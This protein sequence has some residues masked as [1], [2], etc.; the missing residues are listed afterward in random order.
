MT[1]Q[2]ERYKKGFEGAPS[3]SAV[4]GPRA[5]SLDL[6]SFNF[7]V[8]T[9][10]RVRAY[11]G[12]P[13]HVLRLRAME[14]HR[15]SYFGAME[16]RYDALWLAAAAG[17]IDEAGREVRQTL[18]GEDGRD[19]LGELQHARH[20]FRERRDPQ[21]DRCEAFK[22]A[23]LRHIGHDF[24]GLAELSAQMDVFNEA[25]PIEADLP[26]DP[27]TGEY[28]WMGTPWKLLHPPTRE[29]LLIRFPLRRPV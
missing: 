23:W 9:A 10:E 15:E 6:F 2:G 26:T 1:T 24:S 3:G 5:L 14:D 25:F 13:A 17:S 16:Q 4:D 11:G 7:T 12:P 27:K 19:R 29:E 18:L 28:M 22:R 8:S 20:L 21:V